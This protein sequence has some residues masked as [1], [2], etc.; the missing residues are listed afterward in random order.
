MLQERL[1]AGDVPHTAFVLSSEAALAGAE[2]TKHMQAQAGRSSY[3]SGEIL[4][5]VPD[6]GAVAAASWYRAA[7]LAVKDKYGISS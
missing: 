1:N 6:P 7:A 5:S 2:A 3:V 4:S